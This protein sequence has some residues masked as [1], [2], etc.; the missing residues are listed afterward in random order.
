MEG[1]P[2]RSPKVFRDIPV[3]ERSQNI[4]GPKVTF[5]VED[6]EKLKARI[7]GEAEAA[8]QRMLAEATVEAAQIRA[9]AH[10]AGLAQA[11]E[12]AL[13]EVRSA[14]Q[15]RWQAALDQVQGAADAILGAREQLVD[16][17]EEE[18][19]GL[20]LALA[21]RI[22]G[23]EASQP[24][25]TRQLALQ[26]LDRLARGHAVEIRVAAPLVEALGG[27]VMHPR[28]GTIRLAPDPEL[29]P[30]D[31]RVTFD[32]CVADA[33]LHAMLQELAAEMDQTA[34]TIPEHPLVV[35]PPAEPQAATRAAA[36]DDKPVA[37]RPAPQPKRSGG[38]LS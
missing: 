8:R 7:T 19:S 11:R 35:P 26:A 15:E 12:E 30:G 10:R 28:W 33:R 27:S 2:F 9:E 6:G 22:L 37:S 14:W 5:T 25:T 4:P 3:T 32:W 16:G 29:R 18:L 36:S 24:E 38:W 1:S 17:L 20:A 31:V 23:R 34:P 21:A 13:A